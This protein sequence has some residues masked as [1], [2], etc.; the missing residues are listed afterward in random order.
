MAMAIA[1][2]MV[3]RQMNEARVKQDRKRSSD[4]EEA[5]GTGRTARGRAK[6]APPLGSQGPPGKPPFIMASDRQ[7]QADSPL[8]RPVDDVDEVD[9]HQGFSKR[10]LSHC[11]TSSKKE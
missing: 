10:Q 9:L 8:R 1:M 4:M 7:E 6:R 5:E 3:E 2:N 11:R